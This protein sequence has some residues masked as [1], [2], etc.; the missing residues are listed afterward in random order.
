MNK[1][2]YAQL[3]LAMLVGNYV[4]AD[5]FKEVGRTYGNSTVKPIATEKISF[6]HKKE[7]NRKINNLKKH[8]PG[9][10]AVK[11]DEANK[12][13]ENLAAFLANNQSKVKKSKKNNA[14]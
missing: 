12:K 8:I 6:T 4:S 9:L 7:M 10:L 5:Y 11:E 13:I 3:L 2:L 1:K 14:A